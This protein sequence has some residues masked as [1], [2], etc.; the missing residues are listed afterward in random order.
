MQRRPARD[1]L[2]LLGVLALGCRAEQAQQAEEVA[3][4]EGAARLEQAQPGGKIEPGE[5]AQPRTRERARSAGSSRRSLA[6]P[7]VG[8]VA[9]LEFGDRRLLHLD[10]RGWALVWDAPLRQ[11]V[12]APD[13]ALVMID[14]LGVHRLEHEHGHEHE[15]GAFV[16]RLRF[17]SALA[18]AD[19][20][21]LGPEGGLWLL[22]HDAPGQLWTIEAPEMTQGRSWTAAAAGIEVE[23]L[24]GMSVDA[25]GRTWLIHR[26]PFGLVRREPSGSW[27]RIQSWALRGAGELAVPRIRDWG[28]S[29]T[30]ELYLLTARALL[31]VDAQGVRAR[32]RFDE[33]LDERAMAFDGRGGVAI[34]ARARCEL[35]VLALDRPGQAWA[36]SEQ[37]REFPDC[38]ALRLSDF[39]DRGRGWFV[40]AEGHLRVV[41]VD[42][43]LEI[44]T[45]ELEGLAGEAGALEDVDVLGDGPARLPEMGEQTMTTTT[46]TT[47][48]KEGAPR[49]PGAQGEA[50][51]EGRAASE[52]RWLRGDGAPPPPASRLA[53]PAAGSE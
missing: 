50:P 37:T 46:M 17:D 21:D 32:L 41:P 16:T 6:P 11:I 28:V 25:K 31:H 44:S 26:A 12:T 19:E 38:E 3:S 8:G 45:F 42:P 2:C 7:P 49:E 48:A 43:A 34:F 14:A 47:T 40:G 4:I 33:P 15:T 29:P 18:E 20:L 13:E 22:D 10:E 39:D 36:P 53:P 24:L 27:S 5:Q 30:G 1:A 23:A 51:V 35:S 9:Y 52:I